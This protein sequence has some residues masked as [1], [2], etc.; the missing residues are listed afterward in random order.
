MLSCVV[1]CCVVGPGGS[2]SCKLTRQEVGL[3]CRSAGG[4]EKK[5]KEKHMGK[6]R[7]ACDLPSCLAKPCRNFNNTAAPYFKQQQHLLQITHCCAIVRKPRA[8]GF[9][10]RRSC[11]FFHSVGIYCRIIIILVLITSWHLSV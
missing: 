11:F 10:W 5:G 3:G 8:P 4:K 6:K 7:E 2:V 1:L 9:W